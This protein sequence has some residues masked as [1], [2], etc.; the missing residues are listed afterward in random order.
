MT[1]CP[2]IPDVSGELC[3]MNFTVGTNVPYVSDI[4]RIDAKVTRVWAATKAVSEMGQFGSY[5]QYNC[6]H[7][8]I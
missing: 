1:H 6:A 4:C 2:M 8:Y 7:L 3:I 5:S